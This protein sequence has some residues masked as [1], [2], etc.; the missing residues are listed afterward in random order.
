MARIETYEIRAP[1][2]CNLGIGK[3]RVLSCLYLVLKSLF[4]L[5]QREY[6]P[7]QGAFLKTLIQVGDNSR[8]NF[9]LSVW[10]KNIRS[11]IHVGD[12]ILLQSK[13][14]RFIIYKQKLILGIINH[15]AILY[16]L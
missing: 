9:P 12:V 5:V 7:K 14:F 3:V 8:P 1:I 10:S 2:C 16:I 13:G 15:I 4:C 11:I 6:G